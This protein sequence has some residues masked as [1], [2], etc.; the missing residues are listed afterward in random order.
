MSARKKIEKNQKL[1]G[2]QARLE[3][4]QRIV[5]DKKAEVAIFEVRVQQYSK[6]P[7]I[8]VQAEKNLAN[9]KKG[10]EKAVNDLAKQQERMNRLEEKSDF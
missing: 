2:D 6:W 1:K 9:A 5:E 10:V 3:F 4:L 8:K 7:T